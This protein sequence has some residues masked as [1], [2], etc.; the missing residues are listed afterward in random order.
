SQYPEYIS[1]KCFE[2]EIINDEL[3]FDYK[4]KEG[5]CSKLSASYLMNKMGII[6]QH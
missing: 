4:L 2:S 6:N 1:N 3:I 5:V